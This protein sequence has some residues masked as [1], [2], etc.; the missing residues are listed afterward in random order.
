MKDK[1]IKGQIFKNYKAICEWLNVKPTNGKGKE[2]H[3]KEFERY[4]K[5]YKEGHKYIIDEVYETP[6]IKIE[7]RGGNNNKY[8]GLLDDL[9]V[10]SLLS[11][12]ENY[13]RGSFTKIFCNH[14]PLLSENF[15]YFTNTNIDDLVTEHNTTTAL[16]NL[17]YTKTRNKIDSS[18]VSAL[19]RLKKL[20]IIHWEEIFIVK[21]GNTRKIIKNDDKLFK[22]IKDTQ[23]KIC[24]E[25]GKTYYQIL[26]NSN[27]KK[28]F[29]EKILSDLHMTFYCKNYEIILLKHNITYPHTNINKLKNLYICNIHKGLVNKKYIN[30]DNEI[31]NPYKAEKHLKAILFMDE[32][33]WQ[34]DKII[35]MENNEF[36]YFSYNDILSV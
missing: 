15:K 14:I 28:I 26:G 13:I 33:F 34:G 11:T 2:Y 4:C 7:N 6:L 8:N 23:N 22:K 12:K 30:N 31:F 1:L 32:Y 19:N 18:F 25:M 20:G 27:D 5:Y 21:Y 3:L 16:F 35:D 36:L 29:Y 10:E 24:E 9:I 17:Y